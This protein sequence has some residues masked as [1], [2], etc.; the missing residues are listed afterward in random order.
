MSIVSDL[1]YY[2]LNKMTE[3]YDSGVYVDLVGLKKVIFG[4]EKYN[5]VNGIYTEQAQYILS[6]CSDLL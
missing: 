6:V 1:N 4:L 2:L 3:I 5:N